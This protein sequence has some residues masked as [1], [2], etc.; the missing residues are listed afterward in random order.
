MENYVII[1]LENIYVGKFME[2]FSIKIKEK[3]LKS[4]YTGFHI[5][6]GIFFEIDEKIK[7]DNIK[8]L[9]IDLTNVKH[10]DSNLFAVLSAKSVEYYSKGIQQVKI[11]N[12]DKKLQEKLQ[13]HNFPLIY[14]NAKADNIKYMIFNR[15]QFAKFHNYINS[16]F[17]QNNYG[18]PQMSNALKCKII[19]GLGEVFGNVLMHTESEQVFFCGQVTFGSSRRLDIT[20]VNLGRTIKEN[21]EQFCSITGNPL[22]TNCIEWCAENGNTTKIKKTGGLGLTILKEFVIRNNGKMQI[23]SD[24]EYWES[25]K[26]EKSKNLGKNKFNGTIVN[27]EFNLNDKN[28]YKLISEIDIN[29]VF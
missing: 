13:P 26:H 9:T 5:L 16:I 6:M 11:I 2:S 25:G 8:Y 3:N 22:P 7:K 29:D 20:I 1:I 4:N 10:F 28:S 15:N 14:S 21:V 18:L 24:D 19:D 17:S 23:L 27:V 12:I